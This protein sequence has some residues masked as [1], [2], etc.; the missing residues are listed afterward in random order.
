M[1]WVIALGALVFIDVIAA[2]WWE[3]AIACAAFALSVAGICIDRR[4]RTLSAQL[5]LAETR[6]K[7]AEQIEH[8]RFN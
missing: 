5:R 2:A 8:A 4:N 3:T 1:L 6:R 7:W